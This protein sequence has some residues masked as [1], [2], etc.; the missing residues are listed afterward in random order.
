MLLLD[1]GF[2]QAVTVITQGYD[3][4]SAMTA[5]EALFQTGFCE[6]TLSRAI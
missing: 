4:A 3:A 2:G 1:A 6:Q 5:I